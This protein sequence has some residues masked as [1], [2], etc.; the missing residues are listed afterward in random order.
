MA[1]ND[2]QVNATLSNQHLHGVLESPEHLGE[3]QHKPTFPV[4]SQGFNSPP[5]PEPAGSWGRKIANPASPTITSLYRSQRPAKVPCPTQ[6][7]KLI[8]MLSLPFGWKMCQGHPATYPQ[9]GGS[10]ARAVSAA[11]WRHR[12]ES[13]ESSLCHAQAVWQQSSY[14]DLLYSC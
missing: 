8:A 9:Q 4:G 10:T 3:Q 7:N 6:S 2:L 11:R 12:S 13:W 1:L 5:A 14:S